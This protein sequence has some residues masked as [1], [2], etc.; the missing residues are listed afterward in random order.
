MMTLLWVLIVTTLIL[1]I[2]LGGFQSNLKFCVDII[3]LVNVSLYS[4]FAEI[5]FF[6]YEQV[7]EFIKCFLG[8]ALFSLA[9]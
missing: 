9:F 8:E 1:E 6:F 2:S 3:H 4:W 5:F 7:L